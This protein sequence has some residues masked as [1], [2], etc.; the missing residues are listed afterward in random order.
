MAFPKK[1]MRSTVQH[2]IGEGII[3]ST[4]HV[5][6]IPEPKPWFSIGFTHKIGGLVM[7]SI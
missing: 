4:D 5:D 3:E 1:M 7:G 6:S 2:G